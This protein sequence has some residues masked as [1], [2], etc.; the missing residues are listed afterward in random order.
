MSGVIFAKS[1]VGTGTIV[2]SAVFNVL[3]IIAICALAAKSVLYIDWYP[4]T[5]DSIYYII[6]VSALL[7]V[8]EDGYVEWY[9]SVILI[10]L[11]V[12]YIALMY[13]NT[14]IQTLAQS[15]SKAI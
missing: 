6:A 8:L 4:L 1:D 13:F 7:G 14:K 12:L 9:E 10:S 5:R 11:Y 15:K 2:G 3:F